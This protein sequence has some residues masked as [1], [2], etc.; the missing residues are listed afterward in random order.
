M[1]KI[2]SLLSLLIALVCQSQNAATPGNAKETGQNLLA[3]GTNDSKF[4]TENSVNT[5]E[6]TDKTISP[7]HKAENVKKEDKKTQDKKT[8]KKAGKRVQVNPVY[9]IVGIVVAAVVIYFAT[10]SRTTK[11]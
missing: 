11:M 5:I 7:D 1:K 4:V 8:S 6:S 3:L 10:S 9:I 2:F